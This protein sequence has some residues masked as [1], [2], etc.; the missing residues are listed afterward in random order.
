MSFT[1][2]PDPAKPTLNGTPRPPGRAENHPKYAGGLSTRTRAYANLANWL[3]A[4]EMGVGAD[5]AG[6]PAAAERVCQK[7]SYRLSRLVSPD[8]SQAIVSRALH[9][10]RAEFPFLDGVR[11]G[12]APEACFEGLDARVQ[13]VGPAEAGKGVQAVLGALLDLLVGLLGEDLTL[14]LVRDVWPDLPMRQPVRP[15]HS[16]GRQAAS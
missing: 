8:G 2:N 5:A 15:A 10:A 11:G 9:L 14:G 16:N 13:Q 6:L 4:K 1:P 3:L 12:T 7:L